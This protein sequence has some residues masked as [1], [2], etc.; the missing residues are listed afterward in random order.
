MK[1]REAIS[2][3]VLS[4]FVGVAVARG[5]TFDVRT[6]GAKGDKTTSDTKAIQAAI[7]ACATSGGGT[8]LFPPGDY[9]SGMIRLRSRVTLWLDNGATIWASPDRGEYQPIE[10]ERLAE[11]NPYLI[12][13]EK[14]E[15]VAIRG[16]GVIHGGGEADWNRRRDAPRGWTEDFFK[17]RIGLMLLKGCRNVTLEGITIRYSQTWTVHLLDCEQVF[18]QGLTIRNNYYRSTTDG[19]DVHSCR[20]VHIVNCSVTAGDDC[21]CIKTA[22][23][24]PCEN[25]VVTNCTVESVATAIKL[26]TGSDGDFRDIHVSNC[27]VRNSTVGIGVYIKDGG[28]AE[29]VTFSDI[30]VSTIEDAS[31]VGVAMENSVYP[32]F[33]DI[34]KRSQD[35]RVGSVRDLTFRGIHIYSDNG[36]LIQGMRESPIENLV[37]R[38]ISTRVEKPFD[39]GQR[40]KHGG[41]SSNPKDD[42]RTVYAQ[43]P[44]Y[45]TLANI[46]GLVVDNL[47]L[48]VAE[49]V[50]AQFPR[51]ALCIN[52]VADGVVSNVRRTPAGEIKGQ[53]VIEMHNCRRMFVTGCFAPPGTPAL[54]GLTG[55]GSEA[56]SLAGN[57]LSGAARAVVRGDEVSPKAVR[58]QDEVR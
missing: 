36:S 33:V 3:L 39:Y 57:D 42:R 11:G 7:D 55:A 9:R 34:E 6:H 48:R 50:F 2:G 14:A 21:I 58:V 27:T 15:H 41:G 49:P 10:A 26:G 35:S 54:L 17:W 40:K 43:K 38:D 53:P 4:A 37:L 18:V 12:V 47:S 29:R 56:I 24:R 8:V 20:D 52:E 45:F 22:K 32:I 16:D 25:V 46:D 30:S 13:A 1:V 44:S 19:I 5:A 23:G 51:S 31:Q 28:R